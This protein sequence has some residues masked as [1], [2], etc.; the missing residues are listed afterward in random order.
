MRS[1]YAKI[2]AVGHRSQTKTQSTPANTRKEGEGVLGET[3]TDIDKSSR[4]LRESGGFP[5]SLVL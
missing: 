3:E 4:R 2:R 1:M 5:R